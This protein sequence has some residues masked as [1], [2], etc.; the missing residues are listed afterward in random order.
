MAQEN[1]DINC[2]C[3]YL[4]VVECYDTDEHCHLVCGLMDGAIPNER[5]N[6]WCVSEHKWL[7][8]VLYPSEVIKGG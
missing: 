7:E 4:I 1:T 8:C 6:T 5:V 3:P 2:C